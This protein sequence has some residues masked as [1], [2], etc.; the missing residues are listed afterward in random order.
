[1]EGDSS[2]SFPKGGKKKAASHSQRTVGCWAARAFFTEGIQGCV[3]FHEGPK[4][5]V[6]RPFCVQRTPKSS[7]ALGILADS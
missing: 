4:D 2:L 1:M 7:E 3:C 5:A 6:M